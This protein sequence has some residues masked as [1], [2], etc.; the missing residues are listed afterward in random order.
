MT[1]TPVKYY[2]FLITAMIL[3]G[4]SWVAK[5]VAVSIASPLTAGFF[6]F[7]IASLLFLI[8]MSL[9]GKPPHKRYRKSQL[10]IL[11]LIG[12]VGVFGYELTEL[13]GLTLTTS[14]QGSILDG[15]QPVTIGFFAY[16]LLKEKLARRWQ[17]CGFIFSFVGILFVIG[18][19]SLIEFNPQYLA[20]NLILILATCFW[21]IYSTLGKAAMKTMSS[22]EMTAGG[23]VI[24]TVFFACGAIAEQF[25]IS[26]AMRDPRFWATVLVLGVIMSFVTFLLYFESV[27]NI[28][29]TR[30]GVFIGLIPISGTILSVFILQEVIYWTFLVGLVFVIAGIVVINFP[31]R[32]QT[33]TTIPDN[34]QTHIAD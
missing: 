28:G 23:I 18:V 17:Y 32:V 25:W 9:T 33:K 20:G 6:R 13:I 16:L 12:G 8:M 10:K 34:R 15:F 21:A 3:W 22:L 14:G 1:T 30:S 27:K 11:L 4:G 19:Q 31:L 24:G 26:P 5:D 2:A 7:L 29:A